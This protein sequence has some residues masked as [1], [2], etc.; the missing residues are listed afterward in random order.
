LE[1]KMTTPQF[2]MLADCDVIGIRHIVILTFAGVQEAEKR[3]ELIL[4]NG[5]KKK[6]TVK[7]GECIRSAMLSEG[8]LIHTLG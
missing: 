1:E 5:I 7:E 8:L 6:L 2:I 4:A 3:C